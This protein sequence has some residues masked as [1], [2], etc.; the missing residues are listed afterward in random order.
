MEGEGGD[1]RAAAESS[2]ERCRSA[3]EEEPFR[4][5]ADRDGKRITA[6]FLGE[7]DG[8]TKN[9]LYGLVRMVGQDGVAEVIV[10]LGGLG[11]IDNLGIR[12]LLLLRRQ[13]LEDGF[14]LRLV[15][16]SDQIHERFRIRGLDKVFTLAE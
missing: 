12:E 11:F 4:V 9:P 15:E 2:D 6:R 13:S 16:V 14:A 5:E 8:R 7:L 10:D 3:S 1:L